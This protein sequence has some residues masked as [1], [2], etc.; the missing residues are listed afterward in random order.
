[1]LIFLGGTITA[2]YSIGQLLHISE[3]IGIL[4]LAVRLLVMFV[5]L[6]IPKLVTFELALIAS[7]STL[8]RSATFTSSVAIDSFPAP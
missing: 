7:A 8:S 2:Q 1:M 3:Q 4:K 5:M 6:Y